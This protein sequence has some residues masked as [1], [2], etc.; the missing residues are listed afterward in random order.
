MPGLEE[1]LQT[2]FTTGEPILNI[3]VNGQVTARATAAMNAVKVSRSALTT[4]RKFA[5]PSASAF[6]MRGSINVMAQ[7]RTGRLK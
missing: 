6:R 5:R 7:I 1:L 3:E 4:R 2:V